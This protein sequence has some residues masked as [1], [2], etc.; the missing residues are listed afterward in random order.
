MSCLLLM[1]PQ[2]LLHS[3]LVKKLAQRELLDLDLEDWVKLSRVQR[4]AVVQHSPSQK[5]EGNGKKKKK[6]TMKK[7]EIII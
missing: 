6:G 7:V 1:K 4:K 5:E 2:A 3:E